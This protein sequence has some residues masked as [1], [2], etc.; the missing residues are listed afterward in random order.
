[1]LTLIK[2]A[3]GLKQLELQR[4]DLQISKLSESVDLHALLSLKV[5]SA[6]RAE[7]ALLE[8][9][10]RC[11]KL[12]T[13]STE[14]PKSMLCAALSMLC[15]K[16]DLYRMH[17]VVTDRLCLALMHSTLAECWAHLQGTPGEVVET[18]AKLRQ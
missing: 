15:R 10:R 4:L 6:P 18:L 13:E 3:P 7:D 1:M 14:L 5:S 17:A 12:R 9:V 2:S 16:L 8:V 11:H